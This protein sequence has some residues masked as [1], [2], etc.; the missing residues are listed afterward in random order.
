[1]ITTLFLYGQYDIICRDK[2]LQ[3]GL[4]RILSMQEFGSNIGFCI[5]YMN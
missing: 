4:G 1:M 2:R 3:I 5:V